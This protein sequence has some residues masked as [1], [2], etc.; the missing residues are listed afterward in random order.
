MAASVLNEPNSLPIDAINN[1][2]NNWWGD[3][4]G[5]SGIGAGPGDA[6]STNVAFTPFLTQANC[7]LLQPS[8]Q[9]GFVEF[10]APFTLT[11]IQITSQADPPDES[12]VVT[13]C[14]G[15]SGVVE[16][17][18]DVNTGAL[19][20]SAFAW[21]GLCSFYNAFIPE[22]LN[23]PSEEMFIESLMEWARI[24]LPHLRAITK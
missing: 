4:G 12:V 9:P 23:A 16:T 24:S 1:C 7:P 14:T 13:S 8:V 3:L 15:L 10:N 18:Q 20:Y 11:Q 22:D 19:G 5:P 6:V 2:I 21:G 17:Q